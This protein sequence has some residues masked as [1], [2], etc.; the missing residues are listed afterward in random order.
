[1]TKHPGGRPL[2]FKS[3]KE[4]EEKI[5]AY[6]ADCDP[7]PEQYIRYEWHTKEETYKDSK[8]KEKTRKVDDRSIRPKE[9]IEWGVSQ[10][11]HYSITGLANYLETSRE[12]LINYE[13]REQFFDTIKRAKDK[14]EEYWEGL[15]IGSNATGPI[16]NL[17]NNYGWKDKTEQDLHVKE[18]P[19][20]I[21]G[22]NS[23]QTNNSNKQDTSS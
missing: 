2:K 21:L 11:K 7:H 14:V 13:N 16:F 23:V 9:I 15:L 6:F 3:V 10:Q 4:L 19:K 18:L 12:T 22:G 20:P 17:K 1:M 5:N 8:G